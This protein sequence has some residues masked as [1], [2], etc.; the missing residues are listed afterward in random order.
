[1]SA[2]REL[3]LGCGHF[4]DRRLDVRQFVSKELYDPQ[5]P[6]S[7]RW[8]FVTT[9]D[10]NPSCNPDYVMDLEKGFETSQKPRPNDIDLFRSIGDVYWVLRDNVFDEVHAYEVLEHLGDQG[11]ATQFFGDF[12]EMYRVLKPGGF[13]CGSVPSRYSPWLW[14]DPGHRRAILPE[15]L[16]FL[17]R[18]CYDQVGKTWMAD[19][20]GMFV[21][22]W[23]VVHCRDN[24]ENMF[25]ILRAV[26]P[27]RGPKC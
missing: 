4:R 20:R 23:D 11:N 14:G 2:Y 26:K 15:S 10:I 16:T 6:E 8:R 25:F 17:S 5:I 12:D 9:V 19:Y 13:L 7:E 1:M 22:D 24:E 21:G 18:P 3:L 27:A